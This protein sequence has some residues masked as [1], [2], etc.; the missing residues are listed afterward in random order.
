MRV[1]T[2]EALSLRKGEGRLLFNRV[3]EEKI[4]MQID[5][6]EYQV[7]VEGYEALRG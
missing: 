6:K 5:S 3:L 7:A 1:S 2:S 4:G